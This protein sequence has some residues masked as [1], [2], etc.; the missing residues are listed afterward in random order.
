MDIHPP[1]G[2][3]ESFKD[4]AKHV[5]IVTIGI[6]IALCLEGV[7][8]SWREHVA[9]REVRERFRAEL[10]LDQ[11]HLNLDQANEHQVDVQLAQIL[12][13]MPQLAKNPAELEARVRA[14]H[15][16]FY[17]ISTS[18]W[19]SA[20][21]SGALTH[22]NREE[23]ARYVDTYEGLEYYS[24]ASRVRLQEWVA[25]ETYFESHHAYTVAD[26]AEGEQRLRALQMGFSVMESVAGQT[27]PDLASVLNGNRD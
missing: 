10:M 17:F 16:S 26:E 27:S 13:E 15:P 18:A 5:L 1:M 23:L 22:M 20:V 8:E 19:D 21:T 11:N 12:S 14:I 6:L 25:I 4:G 24:Q 3:I 7:R 2:R 9:V